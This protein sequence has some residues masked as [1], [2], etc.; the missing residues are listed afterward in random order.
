MNEQHGLRPYLIETCRQA[1]EGAGASRT[2]IA[3]RVNRSENIII[4][5]EQGAGGWHPLTAEGVAAYAEVGGVTPEMIWQDS[6]NR[7]RASQPVEQSDSQRRAGRAMAHLDRAA[8]AAP[9]KP[10]ASPRKRA[11][12]GGRS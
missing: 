3:A 11:S 5:F 6:L 2:Q 9:S 1:R 8:D 12:G 10:S 7:W 4:R